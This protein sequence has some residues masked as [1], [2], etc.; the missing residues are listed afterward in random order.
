MQIRNRWF[1]FHLNGP[2]SECRH[3]CRFVDDRGEVVTLAEPTFSQQLVAIP[4]LAMDNGTPVRVYGTYQG[5]E[6][7]FN[8]GPN[9]AMQE[10]IPVTCNTAMILPATNAPFID[11]I[12]RVTKGTSKG[13]IRL[14]GYS[15]DRNKMNL[16]G[17]YYPDE[18]E[19]KYRRIKL[20]QP[21]GWIRLRYRKR[22]RKV[23]SLT[24]PL[25]LRSKIALVTMGRAL[26][27]LAKGDL[28][29]S[30]AMDAQATAF[31]N[32]EQ[33]AHNTTD[34]FSFSYDKRVHMADPLQG[35]I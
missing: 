33:S 5:K 16:L 22:T 7:Y 18:T 4:D 6:V 29:N 14:H 25:H 8:D 3:S 23:S 27:A 34:T 31:L 26:A 1:E 21:C 35:I 20:S 13:F 2:G 32:E 11:I 10:G 19:P 17:F 15:A 30:Q 9:G 12:T 24:D 28:A